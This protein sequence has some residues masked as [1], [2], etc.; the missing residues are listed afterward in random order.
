MFSMRAAIELLKRQTTF[1]EE[2]ARD[3]LSALGVAGLPASGAKQGD[4]GQRAYSSAELEEFASRADAVRIRA[5]ASG[6]IP[7]EDD[8]DEEEE[9]KQD[10]EEDEEDDDEEEDTD[11]ARAEYIAASS[12]LT[13]ATYHLIRVET[14]LHSLVERADRENT[15][16]AA[17]PEHEQWEFAR[18]MCQRDVDDASDRLA[19]SVEG[20]IAAAA[21]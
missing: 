15:F 8:E 21:H 3:L 9:K 18:E 19:K 20:L 16:A 13:V 1:S 11:R 14:A 4:G 5:G 7:D 2:E 6:G 17:Y 12:A 10:D